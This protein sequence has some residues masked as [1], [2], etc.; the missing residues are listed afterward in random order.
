MKRTM[1][2]LVAA[3]AALSILAS[4]GLAGKD[5]KEPKDNMPI[6]PLA[7]KAGFETLTKAIQVAGLQETLTTGGPFTVFAPTDEA[8]AK[9]PEGTLE[10]LLA[11]PAS[12]KNVLLYHV[13]DGKVLAADVV[14]LTSATTLLGETITIDATDGVKVNNANVIKTDVMAKNGVIHVIDEVLVPKP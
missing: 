10:A 5:M 4:A 2:A 7:K 9:L 12:L 3:V 8:F 6:F 13:V 11:D 1:Y 14:K